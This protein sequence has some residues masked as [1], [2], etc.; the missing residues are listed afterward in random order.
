MMPLRTRLQKAGPALFLFLLAY[1][2][3]AVANSPPAAP[4]FIEPDPSDVVS[5]FD[6]HF[7]LFPFAD[8][9]PLDQPA[10]SDWEVWDDLL[11]VRVWADLAESVSV[12]H[13]HL[14]DGLLEGALAGESH[15][16]ASRA[17]RVRARYVDDSGQP[18]ATGAWSAWVPFTTD[19]LDAVFPLRV[20]DV[21]AD[22][23]LIFRKENGEP[24]D[25]PDGGTPA[26]LTMRT[27][28]G[29]LLTLTGTPDSAYAIDN[30]LILFGDEP[31][32]VVV[33]SGSAPLLLSNTTLEFANQNADRRS[34]YLP[35][36]YLAANDSLHFWVSETGATWFGSATQPNPVFNMP[37]RDVPVPWFLTRAG[38]RVERVASGFHLPVNL[39]FLPDPAPGSMDALF[40]VT[41]LYGRIRVVTRNYTVMTLIDGLLNFDPVG[42]FPGSGEMGVSGIVYDPSLRS[43]FVTH[44]Y[45]SLGIKYNRVIRLALS[46]DRKSVTGYLRLFEGVLASA[47]HQIS[48]VTIGPDN[49]LYVNIGDGFVSSS[50]QNPGDL[51]GKILRMTKSGAIPSDNPFPGTYL[52]AIGF[53]NPFGAAWQP[54]TGRLFISDNG[55]NANDRLVKVVPGSNYGWCCDMTRGAIINFTPTVAP[56]A[57]TFLPPG[58]LSAGWEN[59]LFLNWSGPAYRPGPSTRGKQIWTY[60]LNDT[61]KVVSSERFLRYVGNGYATCLG[62]AVGP[63]GLY[64]SDLYGEEGFNEAGVTNASIYRIQAGNVSS[65]PVDPPPGLPVDPPGGNLPPRIRLTAAPNPFG[66]SVDLH[67]VLTADVEGELSILDVAGRLVRKGDAGRWPQ[68]DSRWTWDGTDDRGRSVADGVYF[69]RFTTTAGEPTAIKIFRA[70]RIR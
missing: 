16:A 59:R 28:A 22:T 68:G 48:A 39:A 18:N 2:C 38:D 50:A 41:E 52:Y 54:E 46:P 49:H 29:R 61:G 13:V 4:V 51:R 5:A 9:D 17:Y 42:G 69:A 11:N 58:I 31:V 15:F 37:A 19:S 34:I 55:D 57:L 33:R 60:T 45:D 10:H 1:A 12:E 35:V 21:L 44:V 40:Y 24:V 32:R 47:S 14:R 36:L 56:V 6:P 8:P 43:L 64:F 66:S 25:L 27:S 70:A 3:P 20:Q 26:T 53:R 62:L 30:P 23:T 7:N 63:D 67:L 65:L